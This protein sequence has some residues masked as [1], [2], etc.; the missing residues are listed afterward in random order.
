M[1]KELNRVIELLEE[2]LLEE[3]DIALFSGRFYS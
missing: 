3:V 2:Q 1:L